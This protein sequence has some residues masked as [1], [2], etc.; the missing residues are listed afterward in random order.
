M[1]FADTQTKWSSL[2]WNGICF[3]V[4]VVQSTALQ[5]GRTVSGWTESRP[6]RSGPPAPPNNW[7]CPPWTFYLTPSEPV[8]FSVKLIQTI[9]QGSPCTEKSSSSLITNS[10]LMFPPSIKLKNNT[11]SNIMVCG[12]PKKFKSPVKILENTQYILGRGTESQS[13]LITKFPRVYNSRRIN[14]LK[15]KKSSFGLDP[16]WISSILTSLVHSARGT[17]LATL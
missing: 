14:N 5:G 6:Q 1:S 3:M 16:Y 11:Y 12:V 7:Q 4:P 15:L 2:N 9:S 10:L 8:S 17:G 13:L